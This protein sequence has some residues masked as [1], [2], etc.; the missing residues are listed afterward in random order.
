MMAIVRWAGLLKDYKESGWL[1][2]WSLFIQGERT[3][4]MP[5][6]GG[7]SLDDSTVQ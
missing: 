2:G 1:M 4:Y 7:L 5:W 3:K 6:K